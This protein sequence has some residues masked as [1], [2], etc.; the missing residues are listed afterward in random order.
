M[1]NHIL[2]LGTMGESGLTDAEQVRAFQKAGFEGFFTGWSYEKQDLPEIRRTAEET[3]MLWQSIHAPFGQ[4]AKIWHEEGE[5]GEAALEEQMACLRDCA[6][7]GVPRMICH[8]FIGFDRHEPT[9]MGLERF[10]RLVRLAEELR[11]TVAFE[12]VEGEEYL[13]ALLEAFGESPFVGFC[14]D[15]GHEM[16]YNRSQDLLAKYGGLL[17]CTHI[18]DNLGIRDYGGEITWLDDL[19][20]LPFDGIADWD[21]FGSR[22]RKCGYTGELTFELTT[23]SKPDRHENDKYAALSWEQYLAEAYCRACRVAAKVGILPENTDC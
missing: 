13:A 5:A 10:G 20:L 4:I 16:C 1:W 6:R 23:C 11:V 8:P 12:N 14:L 21:G 3:G 19:H 17:C 7:Y 18:N 22:I 9:E 15:T 2:C